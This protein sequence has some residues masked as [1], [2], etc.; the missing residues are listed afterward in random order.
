M[1]SD[2]TFSF[3]CTM[4]FCFFPISLTVGFHVRYMSTPLD[5]AGFS[6]PRSSRISCN[7]SHACCPRGRDQ[8]RKEREPSGMDRDGLARPAESMHRR[9]CGEQVREGVALEIGCP[10]A[11]KDSFESISSN[12]L[13][14]RVPKSR[15]GRNVSASW[16]S[17][18][19]TAT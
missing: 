16:V 2:G 5:L 15:A 8:A 11:Q 17:S 6:R 19:S 1:M 4:G 12:G 13:R 9:R 3:G 10:G 7:V 14:N 18:I